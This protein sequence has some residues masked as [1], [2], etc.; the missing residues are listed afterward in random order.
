MK[1]ILLLIA[2]SLCA[3]SSA[4]A[5]AADIQ[6]LSMTVNGLSLYGDKTAATATTALIGKSSTGV[7]VGVKTASTG[8]CLVTQHKTGTK[9][10]GTSMDSTA[11]YQINVTAGTATTTPTAATSALLTTL[12]W[13]TM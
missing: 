1:T 12:T 4:F 13:S 10:F 3:A 8:Y 9:A 6:A 2:I 5:T 7:G 11:V